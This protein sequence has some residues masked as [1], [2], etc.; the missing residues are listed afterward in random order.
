MLSFYLLTLRLFARVAYKLN[1]YLNYPFH[2]IW[3][4]IYI[5]L[6][7][8]KF[9]LTTITNHKVKILPKDHQQTLYATGKSGFQISDFISKINYPFV[10]IDIGANHGIYTLDAH[11]N[12][13][14]ISSHSIEPNPESFL[15]L[16]DNIKYNSIKPAHFY[17]FA[18]GKSNDKVTLTVHPWHSGLSNLARRG[19]ER[20]ILVDSRDHS[21]FD[22]IY[23]KNLNCFYVIKCDTEGLEP[24]VIRNLLNSKIS[25]FIS[26]LMI[27]ITP[28]WLNL[29]DEKKIINDIG[30]L[31]F[32]SMDIKEIIK[33]KKQKDI[34]LERELFLNQ[35]INN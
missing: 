33:G 26:S 6:P 15:Y 24:V 13:F 19:G 21:L 7:K 35:F 31:G 20:Q 11:K 3:K 28:E 4:I 8:N 29:D 32:R 18:L 17:N 5:L 14:L 2:K 27:E 34:I 16:I 25:K 23:K 22:L 1:E 10:F 9:Y 30:S 12:P